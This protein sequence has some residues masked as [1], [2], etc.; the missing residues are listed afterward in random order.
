MGSVSDGTVDFCSIC[1]FIWAQ[2]YGHIGFSFH[3]YI[4]LV[5]FLM[6][7]LDCHS[8]C[9]LIMSSGFDGGV[10]FIPH[11]HSDGSF[12]DGTADSRLDSIPYVH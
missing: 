2:F 10:D 9:T 12:S 1:T 7:R 11:V 5:Q 3:L 4:Y 8:I 6:V